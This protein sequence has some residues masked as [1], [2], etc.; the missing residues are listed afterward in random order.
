MEKGTL[1]FLALQDGTQGN[2]RNGDADEVVVLLRVSI[3]ESN[4]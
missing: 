1:A 2:A 3:T 4:L